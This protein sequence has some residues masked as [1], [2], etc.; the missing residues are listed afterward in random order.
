MMKNSAIC[1]TE[2]E[3]NRSEKALQKEGITSIENEKIDESSKTVEIN[4]ID[5]KQWDMLFRNALIPSVGAMPVWTRGIFKYFAGAKEEI[6]VAHTI[7]EN[8]KE[9]CAL[10]P[11]SV[12]SWT[13]GYPGVVLKTKFSDFTLSGT[14]LI[15]RSNSAQAFLNLMKNAAQKF[16]ANAVIFNNA[17]GDGEMNK[18]LKKMENYGLQW[19][20]LERRERAILFCDKNFDTWYT[21]A[22]PKKKRK[23]YRRLRKRLGE[24]GKLLSES[25]MADES[26]EPW[27]E[28]FLQLEAAGWKGNRGTAIASTAANT[29]FFREVLPHLSQRGELVFWRLTLDGKPIAMLFALI[30]NDRAWLVKIAYD[31]QY[32]RY[33]PGVLIV[34]DATQ[35]LLKHKQ[36]SM[37]DSC[38]QPNHPMID[39]IW[40]ERLKLADIMISTPGTSPKKFAALIKIEQ[41]RRGLRRFAKSTYYKMM[42]RRT[43]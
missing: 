5:D 42:G 13:S 14:P 2:A 3:L 35:W 37:V 16:T 26:I 33:S 27:I 24:Q 29:A 6:L 1:T 34:L 19:H 21:E 32:Q 28:Q 31:E 18:L 36:V 22:L 12:K 9:L 23:E 38:A 17:P 25:A 7:A 8:Q 4:T 11:M 40:R 20:V 10:M 39:H 15:H 30:S 43:V 41:I